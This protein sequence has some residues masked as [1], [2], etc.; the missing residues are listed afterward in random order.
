M[1]L[2]LGSS[3]GAEISRVFRGD[4]RTRVLGIV[5][6]RRRC[7]GVKAQQEEQSVRRIAYCSS[8]FYLRGHGQ[9]VYF[10]LGFTA[11]GPVYHPQQSEKLSFEGHRTVYSSTFVMSECAVRS[12]LLR[13]KGTVFLLAALLFWY[14]APIVGCFTLCN[15]YARNTVQEV[16]TTPPLAMTMKSAGTTSGS[17]CHR[18]ITKD[19]RAGNEGLA[20]RLNPYQVLG[21][22]QSPVDCSC[23]IRT[24]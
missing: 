10:R 11:L 6:F 4:A 8:T 1:I 16:T 5:G 22:R 18:K 9:C 19:I 20:G 2:S 24:R 3:E 14:Y 17:Q 21:T 23:Y 13:T 7:C 12:S 15:R